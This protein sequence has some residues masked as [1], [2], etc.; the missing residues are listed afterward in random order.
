MRNQMSNEW[1][2]IRTI[3]NKELQLASFLEE[4]HIE[5]FIPKIYE[6]K[7]TD[8]E[9]GKCERVLVPAIHNLV[10]IHHPYS[11]LWCLDFLQRS[12]VTVSFFKKERN[13]LEYVSISD[14]EMQ[15]FIRATD[16]DLQGTKFIDPKIAGAKKGDWVRVIKPGPLFGITGKFIRYGSKHYIAVQ[17]SQSAALL[18]V[19]YTWCEKITEQ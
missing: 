12:P 11:R 6:L 18:K 17:T 13:G 10:F 7:E 5:Y 19:S 2:P 8:E 14:K 9:D 4:Q 15:N 3:Y 1:I 16:P